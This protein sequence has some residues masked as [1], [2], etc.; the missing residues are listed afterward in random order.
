MCRADTLRAGEKLAV[1]F[2]NTKLLLWRS[3]ND[4]CAFSRACPHLG[5]D[6]A[7]GYHD[8]SQL[9][10]PG[11]GIAYSLADGRS[12]CESFRLTQF[13]AFERDGM[14]YVQQT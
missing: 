11:H 4:V 13:K 3:G 8:E 9:F 14:I 5:V 10:C 1:E 2:A 6:L 7:D 12:K